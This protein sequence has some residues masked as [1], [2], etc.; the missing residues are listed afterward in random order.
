MTTTNRRKVLVPLAT[1]LAAG[2]VA[3]GSGATFTSS[4]VSTTSVAS[5]NVTHTNDTTSLDI[6]GIKPGDVITG[7]VTIENTGDLDA[8]LTLEETESTS[9]FTA[10]DL[11]LTLNNGTEDIWAGDF[12]AL[13]DAANPILDVGDLAV[14]AS[15]TVTWT[16]TFVETAGNENQGQEADASYQWVTTQEDGDTTGVFDRVASVVTGG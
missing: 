14:G 6:A 12:G 2:A 8:T 3:I 9:G 13:A 5:G 7:D 16:V 1:L 4:T 11:K 15:T 10:G